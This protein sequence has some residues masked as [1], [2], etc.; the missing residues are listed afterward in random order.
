MPD[1]RLPNGFIVQGVPEGTNKYTVY[2]R[3]M[4]EG[5][6][7]PEDIGQTS[8]DPTEGM[9]GWGK[10]RAGVGQGLT[11]TARSLGNIAGL[12]DDDE[13]AEAQDLDEALL[14]TG[15]GLGGSI[16][17]QIAATLPMGGAVG[18]AARGLQAARGAGMASKGANVLGRALANPMGR[19]AVE[20]AATGAIL[21]NPGD[22]G[23]MGA[24]GGGAGA[25]FGALGK[26]VG[27]AWRNF[28][29]PFTSLSDEAA[30]LQDA[31]GEF[32]PLSHSLKPGLVK[33][34]Y[35][36]LMANLPGASQKIRG[37]YANAVEDLR[38]YVSEM[39]HPPTA[40]MV[41]DAGNLVSLDFRPGQTMQSIFK[42]LDDYWDNAYDGVR[43]SPVDMTGFR[44]TDDVGRLVDDV[45]GGTFAPL[46]GT[47]VPGSQVLDLKNGLNRLMREIDPNQ[48]LAR[49]QRAVFERTIQQL[50]DRMQAS[51]PKDVWDDYLAKSPYY[52]SYNDLIEAGNMAAREG[53][54]MSPSQLAGAT[55]QRGGKAARIGEGT[56]MQQISQISHQVLPDFPARPGI[57][58]VAAALGLGSSLIGAVAGVGTPALATGGL[59]AI[60][61]LMASKAFQRAISGQ[62]GY[63]AK[64]DQLAKALSLAGYSSRQVATVL[65]T[66][67]RRQNED[68]TRR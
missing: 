18:G 33:Q 26:A 45:S 20:G 53:F 8:Y 10:F 11:H 65:A 28:K 19:G 30:K 49:G 12:I 29:L 62:H 4:N 55:A 48:P 54:E 37:Q 3:A 58:Q 21:A 1:Y 56:E 41:D 42:Q 9:T 24:I 50:D 66:E 38:R 14:S 57:Y 16:A 27:M 35:E 39:A 52:K 5:W 59:Y 13:M 61:K 23:T 51:L 60:G 43:R 6:L 64:A 15:A 67:T 68:A 31:T 17:G 34:F 32:I 47:R 7:K 25:G 2:T 46:T 40:Q 22:R 63:A 44:L 36:S